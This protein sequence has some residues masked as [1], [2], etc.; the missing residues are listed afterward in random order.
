M[1][2]YDPFSVYPKLRL[3]LAQKLPLTNLHWKAS[4]KS[5]LRL[6]PVLDVEFIEE[7]PKNA[8]RS[9]ESSYE[10]EE[11]LSC[12]VG[13]SYLKIM[14]FEATNIELYR[15]HVRPF[16][17]EWF[18]QS[19]DGLRLPT[20]WML[21][22]YISQGGKDDQTTAFKYGLLDKIKLDFNAYKNAS[23]MDDSAPSLSS[24]GVHSANSLK[25][26]KI[27]H[28]YPTPAESNQ[29][30]G[31][32]VQ[33]LKSGILTTF[34]ERV[35]YFE[36]KIANLDS[37]TDSE[38]VGLSFLM[39]ESLGI[40][41]H[42]LSLHEDALAQYES[43]ETLLSGYAKK[44]K[45]EQNCA[46]FLKTVGF[47]SDLQKNPFYFS[48]SKD[49]ENGY[50][51]I[52]PQVFRHL[53]DFNGNVF[54]SVRTRIFQNT[55]L[56]FEVKNYVFLREVALV[57]LIVF[58]SYSQLASTPLVNSV[59]LFDLL[60]R[61][62]S[63][64]VDTNFTIL[65]MLDKV[66]LFKFLEYCFTTID[67]YLLF[68]NEYF[69]KPPSKEQADPELPPLG[70]KAFAV[71]LKSKEINDTIGEL[72][73]LQRFFLV[74]LGKFYGYRIDNVYLD[75]LVELQLAKYSQGD[76]QDFEHPLLSKVFTSFANFLKY[77][78]HLTESAMGNFDISDKPRSADLLL[79]D[80][81]LLNYQV[82][83]YE[84]SL[85]VLLK[86]PNFYNEQGWEY[87][88]F[89]LLEV[90]ISC[91]ERVLE[92]KGNELSSKSS[93]M[94]TDEKPEANSSATNPSETKTDTILLA[95]NRKP[96]LVTSY[97]D[98]L[99]TL[100]DLL[101]PAAVRMT[102]ILLSQNSNFVNNN[103][104]NIGHYLT[105]PAKIDSMVRR[106]LALKNEVQVE[107][108]LSK[109]FRYKV[110]P[111][112]ASHK[113]NTYSVSLELDNVALYLS[114]PDDNES[115]D[116]FKY[117]SLEL[118]LQSI[119]NPS[120]EVVFSSMEQVLKQGKNV[121]SLDA[122][123]IIVGRFAVKSVTLKVGGISLTKT[124]IHQVDGGLAYDN[125]DVLLLH[126]YLS[127]VHFE[128]TNPLQLNLDY[129][130][131]LV[132]ISIG[133]FELENS[134][135]QIEAASSAFEL[136]SSDLQAESKKR[137]PKGSNYDYDDAT[138]VEDAQKVTISRTTEGFSVG[139]VEKNSLLEV[140]LPYKMDLTKE[141]RN[142]INLKLK[143][144]FTCNNQAFLVTAYQDLNTALTVAVSVQD[145]FKLQLLFLRFAVGAADPQA[146]VRILGAE[147]KGNEHYKTSTALKPSPL[148]AFGE[149]PVA[150]INKIEPEE[151]YI[152]KDTDLL[153]LIV[154]YRNLQDEIFENVWGRFKEDY[155]GQVSASH[156]D[157]YILILKDHFF[158][159]LRFDL[160]QYAVYGHVRIKHFDI[161]DFTELFEH[162]FPQDR[163]K[164]LAVFR[165]F[166]TLLKEQKLGLPVEKFVYLSS[167]ERDSPE[168]QEKAQQFEKLLAGITRELFINVPIPLVQVVHCVTLDFEN[169]SQ[170]VVGEPIECTANIKSLVNWRGEKDVNAPGPK[171]KKRVLFQEEASGIEH[172]Q[173]DFVGPQENWLISGK[174]KFQFSVDK[175]AKDNDLVLDQGSIDLYMVPLKIG[176]LLLPKIEIRPVGGHLGDDFSMEVD[177]KNGSQTV[178]VVP[179][180]DKV[181]FAF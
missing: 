106:L 153:R 121:I 109:V 140:T 72:R 124:H 169:K 146:P 129:K 148:V 49:L 59:Y 28:D 158:R 161:F 91:L 134:V 65:N 89:Y 47:E 130:Q 97:L 11:L 16:I 23:F 160:N 90:F 31:V 119:Q 54:Q 22:F 88:G 74:V 115:P 142:F 64:I 125:K 173:I 138:L 159:N 174:K 144:S 43:L 53:T 100:I 110:E 145:T 167:T 171:K 180:L 6:I 166:I 50:E 52:A 32:F 9:S 108:D 73:L 176:K 57:N 66:D 163:A 179:N 93:D 68:I 103:L 80:I 24:S 98:A 96:L 29:A 87:V 172:F 105:N 112:V 117:D 83:N 36:Q 75:Q 149:Q 137:I 44:H 55:A 147:L 170:Y 12:S 165:E 150:F 58:N 178:L 164:Y 67:N 62:R 27:K 151:G 45:G 46:E 30:W 127:N 18:R 1:S 19:V 79:I 35:A 71:Y 131:F 33:A 122:T 34:S 181:T 63:F 61:L 104:A 10:G 95:E 123:D 92:G 40:L 168:E 118:V 84:D 4:E 86:C 94:E 107:Y 42:D 13:E 39:A 162:F 143:L 3:D 41:Y 114:H 48:I 154:R 85:R 126:P 101:N 2:F 7:I 15:Q 60:K 78:K 51:A 81:A 133:E 152:T 135:L 25:I 156:V 113:P 177:Y 8:K 132:R 102:E 155:L 56:F 14:F 128:L 21:I 136:I 69:F 17:K 5:P 77:F 99:S 82:G 26:L 38:N 111:F 70:N 157:K 20:D 139:L 116:I 37:S 141:H 175:N 120:E 76:K